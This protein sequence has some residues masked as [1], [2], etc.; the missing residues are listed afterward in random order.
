MQGA[1]RSAPFLPKFI[2]HKIRESE[3]IL[4]TAIACILHQTGNMTQSH[5]SQ[6][7]IYVADDDADD[8][9]MLKQ[10]FQQ[11]TSSHHLKAV[12]SGKA[13]IDLLS[14]KSDDEL[15]CLIVL[16]YNM[17]ELNGK[18]VLKYLQNTERYRHIPKLSIRPPIPGKKN[19]NSCPSVP[20]HILQRQQHLKGSCMQPK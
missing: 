9:E 4:G 15:P 3:S 2:T 10:A 18:E 20:M 1:D 14:H 6:P 5:R 7:T 8:R 13:L 17:P 11:I 12:S 16:D 19:P